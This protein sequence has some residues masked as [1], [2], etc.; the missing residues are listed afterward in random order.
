M[1]VLGFNATHDAGCVLLRDGAVALALEEERFSRR[2]HHYGFPARSLRVAVDVQGLGFADVDAAA[3][4]WNPYRGLLRFGWH[5]LRSLPRSLAYLRMQ[6]GIFWDFVRMEG[7]LRREFGFRGRFRFVDHH[8]AHAAS[9]FYP[10]VF[11]RAAILTVDGTGEWTTT[12]LGVGEGTRLVALRA[13][14]YPHSLGKLYEAI[15]QFLGFRVNGG[16]GKVMGLAPYGE[17]RFHREFARLLRPAADGF[18]RLDMRYFRYQH[19]HPIRYSRALTAL[20]GPPRPPES[21][22]LDRHRDVAATLQAVVEERMLALADT[23]R[24]LAGSDRLCLAGGVALNCVANGRLLRESG[25]REIFVQPAAHDAGAGF[26]AALV[27]AAEAGDEVRRPMRHAALGLEHDAAACRR[28]LEEAGLEVLRPADLAGAVADLLAR[29]RIVGWFQGRA[30]YGPRALGSRSILADPRR[31][32]MKDVLNAKVK[33]REP[34]RPFAPA[35]L[36]EAAGEFFAGL[37]GA[38]ES[39]F[40]LLA[41]PVVKAKRPVVP[42]IT[43]V[44][45]SARVQTVRAEVQPL[46]H[47]LIAAF[48]RRTGVP[49]LLN[50]SFNRRGEPIVERPAEAIDVYLGSEMDA[51][52][53]GP[54]LVRK[55][56]TDA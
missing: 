51:L 49:V 19:G 16:E 42:A 39:P 5:F 46:F 44:D 52:A 50:T 15:T 28:A 55:N 38:V 1:N 30:E 35:V 34:F 22:I 56:G 40:M 7:R 18:F 12:W 54:Y 45:G 11:E 24:R 27:V 29:G 33:R 20:L 36:H 31:A 14:G 21:E 53:L 25:F 41:F 43:H 17:P 26:G 37:G 48:A 3:F 2:K 13:L 32:E 8:L 6:P 47:A 10:S 23:L 9:A 4:Y